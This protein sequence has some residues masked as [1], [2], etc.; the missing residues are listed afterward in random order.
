MIFASWLV[1][2]KNGLAMSWTTQNLDTRS[3]ILR[4]GRAVPL[5]GVVV[6]EAG[7]PVA[8]ARVSLCVKN[9]MMDLRETAPARDR[10]LAHQAN[11][12]WRPIPVR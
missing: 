5:G 8:G 2:H 6:D 10:R 11:G 9:E 4:L 3:V 1:A 7:Q 12:R